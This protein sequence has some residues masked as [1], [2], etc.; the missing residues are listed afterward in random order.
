M[1][2]PELSPLQF[3]MIRLLFAGPRTGKELRRLSRAEGVKLSPP[4]FSR[5]MQ[6]M[7]RLNYVYAQDEET[8][9]GRRY[10]CPRRFQVTDLGVAVWSRAARVLCNRG[11]APARSGFHRH[12]RRRTGPPAAKRPPPHPRSSPTQANQ[13][14]LREVS[15]RCGIANAAVCCLYQ[16]APANGTRR[17]PATI[18]DGTRRVPATLFVQRRSA[19]GHVE[20]ADRRHQ[21]RRRG[22]AV[23]GQPS[24]GT[25]PAGRAA[26]SGS[27]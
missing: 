23:R 26:P 17:V 20:L 15:P 24:P 16:P 22:E 9:S 21:H 11:S 1:S 13:A 14:H 4:S 12:R 27:W 19:R 6:R 18:A 10:V 7:E 5:L 8:A 3:L 2:L 25:S